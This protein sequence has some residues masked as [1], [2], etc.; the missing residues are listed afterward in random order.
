MSFLGQLRTMQTL[1]GTRAVADSVGFGQT[2]SEAVNS[3][4]STKLGSSFLGLFHPR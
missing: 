2:A 4:G 3:T 1:L